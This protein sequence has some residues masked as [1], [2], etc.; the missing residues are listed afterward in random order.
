MNWQKPPDSVD[1]NAETVDI[2][3]FPIIDKNIPGVLLKL[4]SPAES[5]QAR[6]FRTEKLANS[7]I[8]CRGMVR[9][10]LGR[11]CAV[12][13]SAVTWEVNQYGKPYI[14]PNTGIE[15]NLSH[16]GSRAILAISKNRPLGIDIERISPDLNW[17]EI[18]DREFTSPEKDI[19]HAAH[20]EEQRTLFYTFWTRKEALLKG[21]GRGLS[22]QLSQID[23]SNIESNRNFFHDILPDSE[24]GLWMLRDIT[25]HAGY[26]AAYAVRGSVRHIRS[27][28]TTIYDYIALSGF[29]ET[30]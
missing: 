23:I 4:L 27:Y 5:M 26:A 29:D 8:A 20:P 12:D 10:I 15:F 14:T 17:Q 24:N 11:Y 25:T 9:L 19:L 13:P 28:A 18:A 7:F 30:G 2:W 1:I 3:L 16:S 22:I 6:R 21:L